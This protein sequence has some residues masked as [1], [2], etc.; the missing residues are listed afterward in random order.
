MK[1]LIRADAGTEIG[2]GHVMRCLSL[3]AAIRKQGGEACFATRAL[4]GGAMERIRDTG[5]EVEELLYSGIPQR[6]EL[7]SEDIEAT[8][9]AAK[10]IGAQ[11][12]LI[13][14]YGATSDYL[15][16]IRSRGIL[17][18]IIDDMADR[19]LIAADWLL[20]QNLGAENLAY[21]CQPDCVQLLGP[22][23]VLLRQAFSE[24]RQQLSRTFSAEDNRI[25][26]TLGG[27]NT[28]ELCT[29]ILET[30]KGINTRLDIRCI[31]A[32][33]ETI[34]ASATPHKLTI[35]NQ[36]SDMDQQMAWA[37]LSINAGG[38]T[39]WEL[40]CLGTP[41]IIVVLSPDQKLIAASL[42]KE[43]CAISLDEWKA[44]TTAVKL[45]EAAEALLKK[46]EQRTEMSARSQ[47]LVD[48]LGAERTA[49]SL[50]KLLEQ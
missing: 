20:N 30:L 44:N 46:P 6:A 38:S 41:M 47:A 17:L 49:Q 31:L 11:A 18:A 2:F 10:H 8:L 28:A 37:D 50:R 7:P 45:V 16:A 15:S 39:C 32:G 24:T 42:A 34:P 9:N 25:L 4:P 29:Q 21:R 14:H 1:L 19:D 5:F 36:V 48:G 27:S 23:Y 43:G 3:A 26:L 12:I 22:K 40:C 13:D 35:L 33:S